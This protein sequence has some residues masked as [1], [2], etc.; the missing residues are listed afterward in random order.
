MLSAVNDA[1]W[2]KL[3]PLWELIP[4]A[5]PVQDRAKI[6]HEIDYHR[7]TDHNH[8]WTGSRM[9]LALIRSAIFAHCCPAV[10]A[11]KPKVQSRRT[12]RRSTKTKTVS[13]E[14]G[15]CTERP[16]HAEEW[17]PPSY[18]D[19]WTKRKLPRT[20][21]WHKSQAAA[22]WKSNQLRCD[23][24][25]DETQQDIYVW[26]KDDVQRLPVTPPQDDESDFSCYKS[27][28]NEEWQWE[29][30]TKSEAMTIFNQ[31]TDAV[32][33]GHPPPRDALPPASAVTGAARRE[34]VAAEGTE[35]GDIVHYTRDYP[36]KHKVWHQRLPNSW[37]KK[38][39]TGTRTTLHYVDSSG[40][41]RQW[42]IDDPKARCFKTSSG[43]GP[44][45]PTV[46]RRN[47][48]QLPKP[49]KDPGGGG[50]G[51]EPVVLPNEEGV[52]Y[53]IPTK[54]YANELTRE[55]AVEI[56]K[57]VAAVAKNAA[58]NLF[59]ITEHW[60]IDT[61]C[62][63]DLVSQK[64]INNFLDLL[65]DTTPQT[66]RTAN[67]R[68][69]AQQRLPISIPCFGPRVKS[70][71]LVMGDTPSVLTVGGRCVNSGYSFI[72]LNGHNPC[73][74]TSAGKILPFDVV[75]DCP[76]LLS[77]GL[78][79]SVRDPVALMKLTGVEVTDGN[80]RVKA[81]KLVAAAGEA[82]G[83]GGP[84]ADEILDTGDV[85]EPE[86]EE[87]FGDFSE[88]EGEETEPELEPVRRDL[89]TEALTIS[90]HLLHKPGLPKYCD[91]CALG[92]SR[93]P[94]RRRGKTRWP[95]KFGEIITFALSRCWT[96][97]NSR[98]LG[99]T[100]MRSLSST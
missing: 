51:Q 74:I 61:G 2:E 82:A 89:R 95:K 44:D 5:A 99:D 45:W 62:G 90:H 77:G 80:V 31:T 55:Y 39:S 6:A 20:R 59:K 70:M 54:E 46:I 79:T 28:H 66:F 76:Y 7:D 40:A 25:T 42:S 8:K 72:W 60:L 19:L 50:Q 24:F 97:G 35:C 41:E 16:E 17:P 49:G 67:G 65:I 11:P 52:V 98:G 15:G 87:L 43:D 57:P 34:G 81:P 1:E 69:T 33:Y 9:S 38:G 27:T 22:V 63:S 75:G 23:V 36:Q 56:T 37:T 18:K 64:R 14:D 21:A 92:K 12:K 83:S 71:P 58:I 93:Q 78:H 73:F 13:W 85:S 86:D 68:Y 96:S 26:L 88:D 91:D 53:F 10:A 29:D 32:H 4:N 30:C 94:P 3:P 47:T 48:R 84:S 100:P